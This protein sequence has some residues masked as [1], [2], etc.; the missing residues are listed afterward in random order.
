VDAAGFLRGPRQEHQ[1]CGN[2]PKQEQDV[3]WPGRSTRKVHDV[4]IVSLENL[5]R[6][7]ERKGTTKKHPELAQ[8][9]GETPRHIKCTEGSPESYGALYGIGEQ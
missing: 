6:R 8:I 5:R 9:P 7:G 3:G 1:D 2:H 4:L